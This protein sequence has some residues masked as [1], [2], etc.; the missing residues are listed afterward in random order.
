MGYITTYTGKHFDPACP[1]SE[2][3][4]IRDIAHALS[5]TCRGNGQVKT[6]FSVGQHCIHCALEAEARGYG[7]RL[8]LACLLHDASE[9]Y[10]S[11]VP[12][13][14]KLTMPQYKAV[15]ERLLEQIYG[16][17]LG[18]G[19]TDEE[20]KQ[21][22]QIDKDML[23]YDLLHLLNEKTKQDAP[24]MATDFSYEVLPFEQVERRYLELY[25]RLRETALE[26]RIFSNDTFAIYYNRDCEEL[27]GEISDTLLW[28][29]EK[30]MDFFRL[31]K[32]E[33]KIHVVLYTDRDVYSAHVKECGQDYYEWMVADTFDGRINA[34]SLKECR[35]SAFHAQMDREAYAR[36]I[37]HEFVHICQQQVEPDCDGC[38][39]FWEALATN[40]SGQIM[41]PVEICCS[42]EELMYHYESLPDAYAISYR[43]GKYMLEQLPY[44]Q[45][46]DYIR[47]PETL[48]QDTGKILEQAGGQAKQA[49]PV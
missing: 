37:V 30:V 2:K 43:L 17:Y 11:D 40:L 39:W 25:A 27:V 18:E 14:V 31:K 32:P 15:E 19:L 33:K 48:R 9:C 28:N 38:V 29:M 8:A 42:R 23:Y 6:F 7:S 36:L 4:D 35:R 41:A 16:K 49:N 13:P 24:V 3:I 46:Y 12:R 1:E 26:E 20:E 10:M 34:L 44:E 22:K 45:I 5:L 21:V 47:N